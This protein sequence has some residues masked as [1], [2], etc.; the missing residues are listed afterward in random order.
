M[1]KMEVAPILLL[2]SIQEAVLEDMKNSNKE[3]VEHQVSMGIL[4]INKTWKWIT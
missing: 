3:I 2:K 1:T 4:Q